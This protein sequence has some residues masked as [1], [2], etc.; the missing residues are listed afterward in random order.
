MIRSKP[1]VLVVDDDPGILRL[2][3]QCLELEDYRVIIAGDG[4]TALE[5][6]QNNDP[7]LILLDIVMPGMNGFQVCSSIRQFSEVPIIMLTGRGRAEDVVEGLENGADDYVVKP[8]GAGEL[9]ARVKAVLRRSKFPEEIVQAPFIHGDLCV[10]FSGRSVTISGKEIALTPTEYRILCLLVRNAGKV[11]T[12]N[13]LLSEV[14]GSENCDDAHTLQVA[15][16]R[17]RKKLGDDPG[18]PK[19][20]ATLSGVGYSFKKH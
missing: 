8:F 4:K 11:V 7:V 20:I 17:L 5:L 2:V 9:M 18:N 13:Q 12:Q 1:L 19:Y 3:S 10:D 6:M 16:A 14:W 15:V